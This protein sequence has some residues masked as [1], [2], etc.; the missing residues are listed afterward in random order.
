[1]FNFSIRGKIGLKFIQNSHLLD[2][3]HDHLST[4]PYCTQ[5]H[6][7]VYDLLEILIL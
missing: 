7:I 1:M 6:R 2:V 4:D 3:G 5:V